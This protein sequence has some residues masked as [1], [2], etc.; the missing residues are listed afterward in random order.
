MKK[1]LNE[2]KTGSHL[3]L[4][5]TSRGFYDLK[6]IYPSDLDSPTYRITRQVLSDKTVKTQ[7][8]RSLLT[9]QAWTTDHLKANF[10]YVKLV[11][12]DKYCDSI[13]MS[14]TPM[15]RST[16]KDF[17]S[18]AN[19]DVLIFGLGLGLIILPLLNAEDVKSITVIEIDKNLIKIVS[20]VLSQHDKKGKLN[21][22]HRD[23]FEFYKD[24]PKNKKYDCIY[25]DIWAEICSDNYLDMKKL[26][27]R[28]MHRINKD[29]PKS[30]IDHWLF[31]LV[32][33]RHLSE[34][35]Q[36]SHYII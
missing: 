31:S 34:K 4:K 28:Y 21:I 1:E 35:S 20:P 14:D 23:C 13:M 7:K 10:E 27:K 32:K 9:N 8:T 11:H 15:E 22:V 17:I 5:D 18:N 24:I 25:G 16:N 29:N 33:Y 3:K 26:N 36:T 6:D 12:I 30:F 2:L 19:G